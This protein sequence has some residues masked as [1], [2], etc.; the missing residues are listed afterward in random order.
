MITGDFGVDVGRAD[1]GFEVLAIGTD[2]VV[3]TGGR[4]DMRS[5]CEW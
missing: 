5:V 3:D 4:W 2:G 1:R